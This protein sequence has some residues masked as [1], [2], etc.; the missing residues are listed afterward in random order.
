MRAKLTHDISKVKSKRIYKL[1]HPLFQQFPLPEIKCRFVFNIFVFRL[2]DLIDVHNSKSQKVKMIDHCLLIYHKSLYIKKKSFLTASVC[3]GCT[4]NIIPA[5]NAKLC[6][7]P[8]TMMHTFVNN[9][10]TTAC[11]IIFVR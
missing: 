11:I 2:A 3:I 10:Q 8:A 5:I 6:C 4:A 1:E 9:I 7:R